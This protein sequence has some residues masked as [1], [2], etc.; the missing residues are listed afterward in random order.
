MANRTEE[1]TLKFTGD[2]A[3]ALSALKEIGRALQELGRNFERARR[4]TSGGQIL[5][6]F[7]QI[8]SIGSSAVSAFGNIGKSILSLLNPLNVVS[9]GF[10][11]LGGVVQTALGVAAGNAISTLIGK[12][13]DLA[14][15]PALLAARV[16]TL[17][18][19]F[20]F[21]GEKAGYARDQL[22]GFLEGLKDT[23]ITTREAAANL[24]RMIQTQ[25]DLSKATQLARVAQD[26]AVIS[27][28]NSS[29]AFA[30]I[31][32]GIVSLSPIVLRHRGIFVNL[33][34]AY[35]RFASAAGVAVESLSIQQQQQIALDEVL[36]AGTHIAG[37][38]TTALD[39]AGKKLTSL[40]RYVEEA[41]VALGRS[42]IPVLGQGIDVVGSAFKKAE[43][44]FVSLQPMLT[45]FSERV[46]GGMARAWD[47]LIAG[48]TSAWPYLQE[49]G[50]ILG[51][52]LPQVAARLKL[53]W[54]ELK[55]AL[56]GLAST[57][58][59]HLPQMANLWTFFT[60]TVKA[61]L[62]IVLSLLDGFRLALKGQGAQA[63]ANF[64]DAMA[65]GLAIL[66]I[67]WQ[68]YASRGLAWGYNLVSQ[69]A[70][71]MINAA[72]KWIVAAVNY[73]G[74]LINQFLGAFSPPQAGILQGI[75]KWGQGLINQ[76]L[77]GFALADFDVLN[78]VGGMIKGALQSAVA[79]GDLPKSQLVPVFRQV[80]ELAAGLIANFR[81]TGQIS[82]ETLGK[83]GEVLGEGGKEYVKYLRMQLEHQ[84]AL[85]HLKAV[86]EEVAEAEAR[87]F[88]PKELKDKLR[89]AEEAADAK[90]EELSWQEQYLQAQQEG[91]DLQAEQVQA[92]QQ[93]AQTMKGVAGAMKAMKAPKIAKAA[94]EGEI[95]IT[96]TIDV[97]TMDLSKMTDRLKEDIGARIGEAFA[98]VSE[99]FEEAKEQGRQLLANLLVGAQEGLADFPGLVRERLVAA[100]DALRERFPI[101]D[102]FLT[103]LQTIAS[104]AQTFFGP[105]LL[106]LKVGF[107]GFL[108]E[109]AP[110]I[111]HL[112]SLFD[113][114]VQFAPTAIEMLKLVAGYIMIVAKAG[115]YVAGEALPY[116]GAAIS[117]LVGT[118]T[119][120]ITGLVHFIQGAFQM[121]KNLIQGNMEEARAGAVLVLTGLRDALTGLVLG[122]ALTLA[123][124]IRGLV[125]GVIGFFQS[126]YDTIVGG[127]IIP[128]LVNGILRWSQIL[129]SRTLGKIRALINSVISKFV[130]LKNR[131]ISVI[132]ELVSEVLAQLE[133]FRD[134]VDEIM[135][136]VRDWIQEKIDAIVEAFEAVKSAIQK[137][138]KALENFLDAI[139]DAV[140]P[141][142]L[143]P[144]SPT[145]FE[146]GLR[147]IAD[148]M[149]DLPGLTAQWARSLDTGLR[150]AQATL[151]GFPTAL[152]YQVAATAGTL[153]A[154]AGGNTYQFYFGEGAFTGAFPDIRD[155]RDAEDFWER[156]VEQAGARAAVPGGIL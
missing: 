28:E 45:A 127:S 105:A 8:R 133:E 112:Q 88:I 19:V 82:E 24:T 59:A 89:A 6:A 55:N 129:Y 13:K 63:A 64:S 79:L 111:P 113:V 38:Y 152:Q 126:L 132:T 117:D 124:I 46:A 69:F 114:I 98:G 94:A 17:E 52:Y 125:A 29:E 137:A 151:G 153:P 25:M 102:Q 83:I 128:D 86:Q 66:I 147:G 67:L 58:G 134:R 35:E 115:L 21:L 148:A 78:K 81:K 121:I 61:S 109:L 135:T 73:V 5:S 76:Y 18:G 62:E 103:K 42:F 36:Q 85:E 12:L 95:A 84:K 143:K 99:R 138:L 53:L 34:E 70:Q 40:K 14:V 30:G 7:N 57:V 77:K 75:V 22:G 116:V 145:P 136:Q 72:G 100:W 97:P 156:L 49:L 47:G 80:K 4:T 101:I 123:N 10:S 48:V 146:L 56:S 106:N 122:L 93:L 27:G 71:G 60:D 154:S 16:E 9:A 1:A 155:G 3:S 141:D 131:V 54:L 87:G 108:T 130:E 96:P 2:A 110:V 150:S 120:V 39:Y 139:A 26:A 144:G 20:Y 15:Q 74:N 37:A 33:Q 31:M 104:Q 92:L 11:N 51:Q 43:A 140:I 90:A 23:G 41:A 118:A 119:T 149:K 91:V 68:D 65:S 142:W 44:F 32:H 50:Q 107:Q